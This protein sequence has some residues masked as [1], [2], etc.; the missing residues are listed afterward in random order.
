MGIKAANSSHPCPWCKWEL[1]ELSKEKLTETLF[2]EAVNH[3]TNEVY[4][5]SDR[6]HQEA[7]NNIGQMG[8]K[9]LSLFQFIPF[10]NVVID[11]LHL[12][13]RISDKLFFILLMRLEELE[14]D[15]SADLNKR[16][17]TKIFID[18]INEKTSIR[19]VFYFKSTRDKKNNET[20]SFKLRK[21]PMKD[22]L[23]IINAFESVGSLRNIFEC[24]NHHNDVMLIRLSR[25]FG[26]FKNIIQVLRKDNSE[27]F[28]KES[29]NIDLKKWFHIYLKTGYN[30]TPY[31]HAFCFHIPQF[32]E[33]HGNLNCFSMQNL[34]KY[35]HIDKINYFQSTN[36]HTE[37]FLSTLLEKMNRLE[38]IRLSKL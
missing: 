3:M 16:P 31:I 6:S 4:E 14:G 5:I 10:D 25:L 34:E 35:N 22:R 20:S 37:S 15:S 18:F 19:S 21:L 8:Y 24:Q 17:L 36:R 26:M 30:V 2:D 28:E 7:Q 11:I 12:T 1:R 32:I 23:T 9:H 29:L 13:L 38:Y 27:N 33:K